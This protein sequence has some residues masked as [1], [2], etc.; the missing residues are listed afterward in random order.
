MIKLVIS[1]IYF[2]FIM[3]IPFIYVYLQL[4]YNFIKSKIK[5]QKSI[6]DTVHDLTTISSKIL[7]EVLSFVNQV[8]TMYFSDY[9]FNMLSYIFSL[10]F[11][12]VFKFFLFFNLL[13]EVF[14]FFKNSFFDIWDK[15][16]CKVTWDANWKEIRVLNWLNDISIK[17]F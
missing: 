14:L 4:F 9:V 3:N 15:K 16:E 6:L 2:E 11:S 8:P 10:L 5:N 13:L 7:S 17:W 1:W 12:W